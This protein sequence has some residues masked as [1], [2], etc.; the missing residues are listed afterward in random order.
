[1]DQKAKLLEENIRKTIGKTCDLRFCK[2]FLYMRLKA[3]S[4]KEKME[5]VDTFQI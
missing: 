3:Q 1:M 2:D 4:I 5:N